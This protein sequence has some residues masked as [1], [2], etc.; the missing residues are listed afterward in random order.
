M[1]TLRKILVIACTIALAAFGVAACGSK[2]D[3]GGGGGGGGGGEINIALTSFPD[4][5]D[6]QLSYT[7]E[8]WE[9]LW[10]VYTPLLT[11]KHAKGKDGTQVVPALAEDMPDI[12]P[13][14]KTYKLKLRPNMKYSD[15][16]PIKASDFA[17]GIQRLFKT[18]SGGS[19]FYDVIV[20][21]TDYADGK[22]QT[23]S[24]ASRPTTTPATSPSS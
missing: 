12:S 17:Y 7:V 8:G 15:G 2:K 6:P 20:G 14:G 24:A 11:Y 3:Q 13:D 21:A 1:N 9:V 4:Y 19:V 22:A 16:T 18:D 5:V 10:N 23:R